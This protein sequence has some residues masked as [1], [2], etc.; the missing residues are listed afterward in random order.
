MESKTLEIVNAGLVC[1]EKE[2]A[3]RKRGE[4][5]GE[6]KEMKQSELSC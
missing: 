2:K 4:I 6:D 3:T 1:I 5:K